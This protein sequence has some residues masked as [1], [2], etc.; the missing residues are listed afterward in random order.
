MPFRT[1]V[2][3]DLIELRRPLSE[4]AELLADFPWDSEE[5]LVRLT[6]EN[7]ADAMRRFLGGQLSSDEIQR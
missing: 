4:V 3:V 5:E 2:L 7:V 6:E 1:N